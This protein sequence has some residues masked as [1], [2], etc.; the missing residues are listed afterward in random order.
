MRKFLKRVLFVIG[1]VP[2]MIFTFLWWILTGAA[3]TESMDTFID[4]TEI[5]D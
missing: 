5:D 1:V 2:M 3:W 4:F